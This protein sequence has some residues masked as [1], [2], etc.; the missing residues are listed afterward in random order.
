MFTLNK[1]NNFNPLNA[2]LTL[3]GVTWQHIIINIL[4]LRTLNPC[5]EVIAE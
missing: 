1:V 2:L 5:I 4:I 3:L